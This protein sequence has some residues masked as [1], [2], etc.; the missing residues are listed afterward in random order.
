MFFP[1]AKFGFQEICYVLESMLKDQSAVYR[2]FFKFFI[3]D[4]PL[5]FYLFFTRNVWHKV[6]RNMFSYQ[7]ICSHWNGN[8]WVWKQL[9]AV[10]TNIDIQI[11]SLQAASEMDLLFVNIPYWPT[12]TISH[13][14]PRTKALFLYAKQVATVTRRRCGA[15]E[16]VGG[17][18]RA[19]LVALEHLLSVWVKPIEIIRAGPDNTVFPRPVSC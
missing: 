13:T 14:P 1:G 3:L 5:V 19:P 4:V 11:F 8:V 2:F 17:W 12:T 6:Y 9:I 15:L 7:S 16:G 18:S 10:C